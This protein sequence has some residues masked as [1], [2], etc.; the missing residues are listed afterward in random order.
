MSYSLRQRR[1]KQARDL[2]SKSENFLAQYKKEGDTK[3]RVQEI[4]TKDFD[5]KAPCFASQSVAS[6][7]GLGL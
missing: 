1:V 7:D 2:K 6:L 4:L 5:A 3:L